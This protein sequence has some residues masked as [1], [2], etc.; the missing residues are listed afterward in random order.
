MSKEV[1]MYFK[2]IDGSIVIGRAKAQG[3]DGHI[4]NIN[5]PYAVK[6]GKVIPL[7]LDEMMDKMDDVQISMMN[8]LYSCHLSQ[9]DQVNGIYTEASTDILT[10]PP[11][12]V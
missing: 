12:V 9:F 6:G 5:K 4:V 8:V 11:I 1:K 3:T 10:K 2:L 7:A